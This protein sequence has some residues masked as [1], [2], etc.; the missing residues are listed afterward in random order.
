MSQTTTTTSL[1]EVRKHYFS[2]RSAV[3]IIL[4]IGTGAA[5]TL[6]ALDNAFG[7]TTN[8]TNINNSSTPNIAWPGRQWHGFHQ[9]TGLGFRGVSTVNNV[10]ITGFQIVDS[11][12]VTI[13]LS[14]GASGSTPAVTIVG[15]AP[16]MS[17][18]TTLAA[19]WTSPHTVSLHL[20]GTGTLSTTGSNFLR[21]AVVP[22]TGS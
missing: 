3:L 4:L 19:G 20:I 21:I 1:A 2:G 16:G 18:S 7:A 12:H 17:G 10:T 13:T 6:Y 8:S 9:G 5:L 15:A 11:S 14:Y 22:L